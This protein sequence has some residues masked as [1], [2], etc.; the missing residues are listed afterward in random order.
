VRNAGSQGGSC[1]C[2]SVTTRSA[3]VKS[4]VIVGNGVVVQAGVTI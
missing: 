3:V 1:A 4:A 2:L